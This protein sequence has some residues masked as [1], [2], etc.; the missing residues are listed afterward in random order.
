MVLLP[1][2]RP[3]TGVPMNTR[4]PCTLAPWAMM[5]TSLAAAAGGAV[6]ASRDVVVAAQNQHR[7]RPQRVEHREETIARVDRLFS[8]DTLVRRR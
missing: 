5:R 1:P 6:L 7:V 8:A 2:G 3:G 4:A